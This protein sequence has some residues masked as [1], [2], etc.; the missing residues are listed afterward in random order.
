MAPRSSNTAFLLPHQLVATAWID[1][2][3]TTKGTVLR[4]SLGVPSKSPQLRYSSRWAWFVRIPGVA[5]VAMVHV[6][7][8][9]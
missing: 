8:R 3:I 2:G 7:S 6:E 5:T 4:V 1:G 9:L